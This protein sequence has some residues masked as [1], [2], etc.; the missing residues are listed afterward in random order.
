MRKNFKIIMFAIVSTTME[1]DNSSW[2]NSFERYYPATTGF[3]NS[4]N[5]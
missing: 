4:I 5:D 3:I 2:H 1:S